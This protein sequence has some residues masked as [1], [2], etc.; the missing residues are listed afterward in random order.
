MIESSLKS[1]INKWRVNLSLDHLAFA[2]P[3]CKGPLERAADQM[4]NSQLA[5]KKFEVWIYIWYD[6]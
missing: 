4:A 6:S 5:L 2:I 1:Q 3:G